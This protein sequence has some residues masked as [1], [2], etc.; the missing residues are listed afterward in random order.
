M[1][2]TTKSSTPGTLV[3]T[4]IQ[5]QHP[6]TG[7]TGSF[8][9]SG[10]THRDPASV[11]SPVFP[12]LYDLYRWARDNGFEPVPGT[13][14]YRYTGQKSRYPGQ[15]EFLVASVSANAN[16]FG[17]NGVILI[18]RD[19]EALEAATY[20]MDNFTI[21]KGEFVTLPIA[22]P[23]AT[24]EARYRWVS[25]AGRTF[26][27]PRALPKCPENVLAELFPPTM[28]TTRIP[29]RKLSA[30]DRFQFER[31]DCS[32]RALAIASGL[33]YAT[34]HSRCQAGGRR[35]KF[36]FDDQKFAAVLKTSGFV[37]C[38]LLHGCTLVDAMPALAHG[39]FVVWAN[40]HYFAV[41]HGTVTDMLA[42]PEGP[43]RRIKWVYRLT[44]TEQPSRL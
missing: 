44:M 26:E 5:C 19:G 3:R 39:R 13:A 35:S 42:C 30:A 11:H 21:K 16:S 40:D 31:R 22:N 25:T 41:V 8:F 6:V 9:F 27:I 34:A 23:G 43:R 7:E 14:E 15:K 28:T 17:L 12:S 36:G 4:A 37:K 18:A 2:T 33:P 20:A 10:N 29:F 38:P 32:V 1:S 24:G